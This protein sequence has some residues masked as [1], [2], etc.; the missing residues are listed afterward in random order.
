MLEGALGRSWKKTTRNM[1]GLVL[2]DI[3]VMGSIIETA[4]LLQRGEARVT[5]E[6]IFRRDTQLSSLR[7]DI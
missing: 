1:L 3:F 6:M 5:E 4:S 7:S 2:L